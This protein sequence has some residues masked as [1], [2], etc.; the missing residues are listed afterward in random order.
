MKVVLIPLL[1]LLLTSCAGTRPEPVSQEQLLRDVSEPLPQRPASFEAIFDTKATNARVIL[2][3]DHKY[4]RSKEQLRDQLTQAV[5]F[6]LGK[7]SG[8]VVKNELSQKLKNEII[9]AES[10]GKEIG[11]QDIDFVLYM[12]LSA[13]KSDE[14]SEKKEKMFS[15]GNYYECE[16]EAELDG[17]FRLVEIPSMRVIQQSEF[18]EDANES[19]DLDNAN[20]CSRRDYDNLFTDAHKEIT[21][22]AAC[23][24]VDE[25]KSH[26]KSIG[27]VLGKSLFSN[28]LVY[29]TSLTS[30]QGLEKG[31]AVEFSHTKNGTSYAKGIVVKVTSINSLIK[32]MDMTES[33]AIYRDDF[34]KAANNTSLGLSCLF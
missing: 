12:G 29:E 4:P 23:E 9:L 11:R 20:H 34:I 18:N 17:W 33:E 5:N 1:T 21:S 15:D 10:S 19:K 13:Y 26:L 8:V 28:E 30:L 7:L 25:M 27:H 14:K 31:D 22:N 24:A 32:L 3:D 2:I 16:V 6:R